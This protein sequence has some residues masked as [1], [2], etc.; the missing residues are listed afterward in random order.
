VSETVSPISTRSY[1]ISV[2]DLMHVSICHFLI[3]VPQNLI[4]NLT[5]QQKNKKEIKKCKSVWSFQKYPWTG[6]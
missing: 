6:A 3:T 4:E 5:F 2:T 1:S